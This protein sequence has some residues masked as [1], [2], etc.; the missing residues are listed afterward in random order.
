MANLTSELAEFATALRI[1]SISEE[2]IDK[3]RQLILDA[4]GVALG[5]SADVD[6]SGPIRDAITSI[7]GDGRA[8]V[9]GHDRMLAA[10]PAA[11]INASYVHSLDFDDTHRA[12]SVHPGASVIPTVLALAEQEGGSGRDVVAAIVAGYDVV[13][14]LAMALDPEAHYQRGFH[15]TSTAGT[16]GATAAGAR[17]LGLTSR[18]LTNAF[19]INGSQ[20]AGS[21]QFLSN[22]AWNKRIHPGLAAHN[23]IIAL[24]L[25]RR[26]FRGASEAI[27]G[28]RGFLHSYTDRSHQSAAVAGLGTRFEIMHTGIKPY[29]ACRYAHG[30]LDALVDIVTRHELGPNDVRR[31]VVELCDAAVEIIGQPVERKRHPRSVV[32]AQ[33]SMHFLAAVAISRQRMT[34][35]DYELIGDASMGELMECIEVTPAAAANHAYPEKWLC[36][37]MVET[38]TK[39]FSETRENARGDPES[40]LTWGELIEKFNSLAASVLSQSSRRTVVQAV[41]DM[42]FA[43]NVS[44][45]CEALRTSAVGRTTVM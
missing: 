3:A 35:A 43:P 39:R 28:P 16:F 21:L 17:L 11:F 19:G 25:A 36:S 34:W 40:P 32:D 37:V 6:S 4:V 8:T 29:P 14:K 31:V 42:D 26:G 44:R 18:E 15:P 24:E 33:F 1:E 7:S 20:A 5:A 27:E 9:I 22:G 38:A 10:A 45:L 12:G 23:A 13:C 41:R 2:V 30:A